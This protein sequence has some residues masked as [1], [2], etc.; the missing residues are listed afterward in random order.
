M[1]GRAVRTSGPDLVGPVVLVLVG[2]AIIVAAWAAASGQDQLGDQ[3]PYLN[4]GVAGAVIAAAGNVLY[5]RSYRDLV[6]DRIDQRTHHGS[7][8]R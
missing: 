2:L 3:L 4:L 6:R 8:A 5:L 1:S 7:T